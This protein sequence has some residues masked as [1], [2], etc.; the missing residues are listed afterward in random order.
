MYV[1]ES[2]KHCTRRMHDDGYG[3]VRN[4]AE[5]PWCAESVTV[6]VGGAALHTTQEPPQHNNSNINYRVAVVC[7]VSSPREQEDNKHKRKQYCRISKQA[8]VR[9]RENITPRALT[10]LS[11]PP[12][13]RALLTV[14]SFLQQQ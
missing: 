11:F 5:S 8:R 2:F 13:S 14:L 4:C 9:W 12:H 1:Q 3:I 6:W 10:S 7:T